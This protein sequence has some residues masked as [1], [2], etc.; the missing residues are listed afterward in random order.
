MCGRSILAVGPSTVLYLVRPIPERCRVASTEELP[1]Y[2]AVWLESDVLHGGRA[3]EDGISWPSPPISTFL[4]TYPPK[5]RTECLDDAR[6]VPTRAHL[7]RTLPLVTG[8]DRDSCAV[9]LAAH[10]SAGR[11]RCLPACATGLLDSGS[12]AS[13]SR[14][15]RST[16]GHCISSDPT[17]RSADYIRSY[18]RRC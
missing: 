8:P 16:Y 14:A 11:S 5:Q 15:I 3:T 10:V 13:L 9:E 6:F 4:G 17:S 18:S 12:S 1:S 7:T 2:W